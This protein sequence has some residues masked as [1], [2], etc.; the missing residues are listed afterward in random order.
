MSISPPALTT[1]VLV[2]YF[3]N[4]PL[5]FFFC[6]K[7][8]TCSQC[9]RHIK[10]RKPFRE[11]YFKTLAKKTYRSERTVSNLLSMTVTA[12]NQRVEHVALKISLTE[13]S[14]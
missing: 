14:F 6:D 11:N 5:G 10:I 9:P 13:M 8:T 3:P 7:K 1:T 12:L 4:T 2:F